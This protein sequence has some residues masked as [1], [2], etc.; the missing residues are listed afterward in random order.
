MAD[1][2]LP[3]SI[4]RIC[5]YIT[6]A[7]TM[8]Q[9]S[10]AIPKQGDVSLCLQCA[11]IS[12]FDLNLNLIEPAVH[13]LKALEEDLDILRQRSLILRYGPGIRTL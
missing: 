8:F 4:C 11:A 6:D 2:R 3:K 13:L 9:D 7:A 1:A 12:V 10:N 5:G